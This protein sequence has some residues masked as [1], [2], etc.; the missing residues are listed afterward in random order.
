MF[1]V[2]CKEA[3]QNS[4]TGFIEITVHAVKQDADGVNIVWPERTYGIEVDSL[5]HL[6]GGDIDKWLESV[7][8]EH[9]NWAGMHDDL[10]PV[11]HRLKGKAL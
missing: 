11:L 8:T 10:T 6:H 2:I 5:T 1:K 7:K 9:Q 4:K 3:K